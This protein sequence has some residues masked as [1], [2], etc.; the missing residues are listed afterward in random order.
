MGGERT[1]HFM[2][3]LMRVSGCNPISPWKCA[4]VWGLLGLVGGFTGGVTY[5]TAPPPPVACVSAG[6]L[7]SSSVASPR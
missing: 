4:V 7:P 2:A 3:A 1:R 6:S 5:L